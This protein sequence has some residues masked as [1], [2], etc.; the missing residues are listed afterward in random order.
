[1]TV[2]EAVDLWMKYIQPLKTQ[3]GVRLGTPATSSAPSGKNWTQEFITACRNCTIDFVAL[4]ESLPFD[5]PFFFGPFTFNYEVS[6]LT[7]AHYLA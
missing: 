7:C 2:T 1:M 3:Y 5:L 6:K 4:R